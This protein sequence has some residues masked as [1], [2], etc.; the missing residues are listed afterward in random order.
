M[1]QN[2]VPSDFEEVRAKLRPVIRRTTERGAANFHLKAGPQ[3]RS[4][5]FRPS[6]ENMEIGIAYDGEFNIA[7][8]GEGKLKE[9]GITFD[10]AYDVAIDNLRAQSATPFMVLR[11]AVF[12]SQFGDFYDAS[13]LLLTDLLYRQPINGAPVVMVPNRTVLLLTGDRNPE[14]LKLM[15]DIAIEER[16][17]PRPLPPLMLRWDGHGWQSFV[18]PGLESKLQELRVQELLADYQ[19]QVQFLNQAHER[20]GIKIFVAKYLAYKGETGD[21]FSA[22]TWTAVVHSLLP[23]TDIVVLLRLRDNK[24]AFLPWAELVAAC[25]EFL[26]PSGNLPIRYKVDGFPADDVF[27]ALSE[28]FDKLNAGASSV[29]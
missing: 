1:M 20:D 4:M 26:K 22:C 3:G 8:L 5:A 10:E 16:A 9:W 23:K 15:L 14:G 12:A 29:V 17:K 11:N 2:Y 25:G 19:D 28:R 24:C 13:R 18:P 6:C 7:R 21:V 27:L